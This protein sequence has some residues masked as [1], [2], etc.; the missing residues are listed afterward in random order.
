MTHLPAVSIHHSGA[1][2]QAVCD[3]SFFSFSYLYF[4]PG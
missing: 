2:V 1:G 4:V 3:V